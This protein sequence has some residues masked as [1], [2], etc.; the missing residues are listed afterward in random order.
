MQRNFS[1]QDQDENGKYHVKQNKDSQVADLHVNQSTVNICH[2]CNCSKHL[3]MES[4]IVFMLSMIVFLLA[5]N[6]RPICK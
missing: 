1:A 2:P 3:S 5:N 4:M 6:D